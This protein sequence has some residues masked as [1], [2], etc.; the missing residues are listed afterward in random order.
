MRLGPFRDGIRRRRLERARRTH[1]LQA[2]GP[3]VPYVPGS[4]HVNF[5]PRR[6]GF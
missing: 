5:L 2:D 1:A 3:R 4:E 6:R